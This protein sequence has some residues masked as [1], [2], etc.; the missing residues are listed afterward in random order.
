MREDHKP[1]EIMTLSEAAKFIRVSEKTLGERARRG[2]IPS[3]K[4]GREWRFLRH[5]L[6]EWLS[7][8]LG[9]NGKVRTGQM[10]S[11]H[12]LR[13]P[14]TSKA[15]ELWRVR[16]ADWERA[17]L[18]RKMFPERGSTGCNYLDEMVAN[19]ARSSLN[20]LSRPEEVIKYYMPIRLTRKG[21]IP[22]DQFN[23]TESAHELKAHVAS[24]AT[25]H[26]AHGIKDLCSDGKK[27]LDDA[28]R[29][30]LEE[31]PRSEKSV[32]G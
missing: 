24:C 2:R 22:V 8:R 6:E 12:N 13:R 1:H 18:L 10:K 30:F 23:E 16:R 9:S 19:S 14:R 28:L 26:I 4:V 21:P 29:P 20:H 7:G 11:G 31:N 17:E 15:K 32:R 25:C 5:A 3:Q 27:W